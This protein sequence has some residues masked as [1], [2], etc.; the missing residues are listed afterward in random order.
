MKRTFVNLLSAALIALV[1]AGCQPATPEPN[2]FPPRPTDTPGLS[3]SPTADRPATVPVSPT[4]AAAPKP[5]RTLAAATAQPQETP[6]GG[7]GPVAIEPGLAPQVEVA[8][9]DLAKRLSL[10]PDQIHVVAAQAVTWPDGSLGC[11]KPGMMYTQS[12]VD[13]L[14][15]RMEAGGKVYEYHGGGRGVPFFCDKP[16]KPTGGSGN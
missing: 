5:I 16:S 11:P 15:I 7:A 13:G 4:A 2:D 8:R 9:A 12:L 14:L 10:A 1:M 3:P 6:V